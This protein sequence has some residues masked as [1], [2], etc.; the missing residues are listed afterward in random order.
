[1]VSNTYMVDGGDDYHAAVERDGRVIWQ[2]LKD[3]G[4]RRVEPRLREPTNP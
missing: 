4:W 3:T 2:W 1:M